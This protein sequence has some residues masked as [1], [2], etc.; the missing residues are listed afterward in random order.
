[1]TD[2]AEMLANRWRPDERELLLARQAAEDRLAQVKAQRLAAH[3]ANKRRHEL[4]FKQNIRRHQYDWHVL[5][6]P[7]E[8][9]P[10]WDI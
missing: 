5:G 9:I 2:F 6:T 10:T 3:A 4:R 8:R 1:M 7:D